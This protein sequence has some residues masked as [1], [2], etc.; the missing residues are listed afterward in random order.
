MK[1]QLIAGMLLGILLFFSA[2]S[3]AQSPGLIVRPAGGIGKTPLNLNGDAY[4]S[5]TDAGFTTDDLAQSEVP[6]KVVPPA[7]V[8]PTGDLATGP[9]GGFTDIVKTVDGSG[10]YI[11]KDDV[12]IY[13]RLRIG[14]IISGS[15]GYSILIDTDG[16][17]GNSGPAADY[18]YV[19]P[20][21]TSNGNPGF[22]YEVVFR[23]NFEVT[24]YKVDGTTN[25]VVQTPTYGLN[26]NT[27]ISVAL[28]ADGN[29]A[30]YFYDWFVPLSAI[31]NPASIR[32]VATT[33]TSPSSALQGS[34]S[35]I[36]GIDDKANSNVANAWTTV[37]NAQPA[38]SLTNF[39]T[40]ITSIG[41][42]C[43]AAPTLNTPIGAAANVSVSGTWTR[44]DA[45]KPSTAIITLFK[46][47]TALT[48]TTTVASGGTWNITI[49]TIANGD[50]IYAKAQA[51]GESTCLES[52]SVTVGCLAKPDAPLISCASSKG[53]TGTV[54]AGTTIQ[55]YQIRTD[56]ADPASTLITTSIT[57]TGTAFYY[58]NNNCSGSGNATASGTY[59]LVAS[60]GSCT[61]NPVFVCISSA[62][63]N[64]VPYIST[65]A[66]IKIGTPIY[67]FQ[68][69]IDVS[70]VASG[71]LLRL[72]V[73]GKFVA[74]RTA[75]GTSIQFTDLK[76]NADDA[77][78]I[79]S[80]SGT[81]CLT[82]SNTFRVSCYNQPPVIS[83]SA[84]GNLL[85][86][87]NL[88]GTI[89][90]T[91][92]PNASITLN[93]TSPTTASWT[94]TANSS[95]VW[96][97]S[98]LTL[99]GGETYSAT[100]TSAACTTP[101]Q[102]SAAALVVAPTTVC[103][104][105][106]GS[107]TENSTS[108]S[109]SITTTATGT[110][111]LYL[112]DVLVGSVPVN[113]TGTSNWTN[114]AL[115]YPLYNGGVLKATFQAGSNAENMNCTATVTVS[116]TSPTAPSIQSIT[117]GTTLNAGQ[118]ATFNVSNIAAGTWY[119]ISDNN[120]KS[121][122]TSVY[123][124]NTN[125]LTL[126]TQSFNTA[127]T[128]DLKVTADKLTGCPAS[129]TAA[130][131]LVKHVTLPV[132]FISMGVKQRD[133]AAQ[134]EWR[135]AGEQNVKYYSVEKSTDCLVFEE[136]GRVTYRPATGAAGS[137]TF[138]DAT[139]GS[140][141][142]VCYRIR[143]VDHD[144]Q[145]TYSSIVSL[146]WQ[147][148]QAVQVL[149]NP[150]VSYAQVIVAAGRQQTGLLQLLS[151]SGEVVQQVSVKLQKGRNAIALYQLRQLAKESYTIRIT[152]ADGPLYQKIIIQ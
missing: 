114:N 152:T 50:V 130:S 93:R 101:S 17:M 5:K 88:A 45:T 108:V 79:Y 75:S 87:V 43:T 91:A 47:G 57:Q 46:N 31:G 141:G 102:A 80:Q 120:G 132:R 68:T 109:G 35:D 69:S 112:D 34:R 63:G 137:Y 148:R 70:G 99:T 76:L 122:A 23:T 72:F 94:T 3:S 74:S 105:I 116:C 115:I 90:G 140:D 84:S 123:T 143:Q 19:A 124:T 77:L 97:V 49:P 135:V 126:A 21:N 9:S 67:P 136:V 51:T 41:N 14:G 131:L 20:T 142:R 8:E 52:N 147:S 59:M 110:V 40:Y 65:D 39:D 13:F 58:M 134:L 95:G 32:M 33:V 16:R 15:K 30:D 54:P 44:M 111:R 12:N 66:N 149:P 139:A 127:G 96:S 125:N 64:S 56:A 81:G 62:G 133:D 98:G 86:S 28:S 36:Y 113:T 6:Y 129:L 92:A 151:S 2:N 82:A 55:I 38:I 26:S 85:T 118:S 24:V 27:Q 22:E 119:A 60:N 29:N 106:T 145:Y 107:Y 103:P 144:G 117:P 4:A 25:P 83:T 53:I 71:A 138:S 48:N 89:S 146:T 7:I 37:V 78:N 73:N 11:Y 10:F 1:N 128:Y 42:T 61:S 150:A 18:N 121:Y 100:V 104:T